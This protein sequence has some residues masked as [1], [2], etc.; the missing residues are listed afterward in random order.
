MTW[1]R[2]TRATGCASRTGRRAPNGSASASRCRAFRRTGAT[3]RSPRSTPT[4]DLAQAYET[5]ITFEPKV[6]FAITPRVRVSAGVSTSE[7]KPLEIGLESEHANAFVTGVGYDQTWRRRRRASVT[8]SSSE[9]RSERVSDGEHT[10]RATYEWRAGTEELDSDLIYRR[11]L[12]RARF[13][14]ER[15][16]HVLHRGLSRRPHHRTGAALRALHARRFDDAPRLEQVR[17][18]PGGRR[19]HVA[20]VGRVQP[21]TCSHTSSTPARSGTK[22]V[23]GRSAS[24]RAWV[25]GVLSVGFPLNA[26]DGD[27]TFILNVSFGVGF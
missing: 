12:G 20:P 6:T 22:A 17:H 14:T 27:A 13:R 3:S 9:K 16:A 19:P 4:P 23:S 10:I 7:L 5:R 18:R 25:S 1:S 8:S 2:S 15:G 26:D 21:T 11:H 24:R